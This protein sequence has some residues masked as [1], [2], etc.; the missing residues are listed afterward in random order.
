MSKFDWSKWGEDYWTSLAR[1]LGTAGMAWLGTVAVNGTGMT[2][3]SFKTLPLALLAGAVLPTTFTFIQNNPKPPILQETTTTL[4]VKETI[5]QE[6]KPV[7]KDN[8]T[9]V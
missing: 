7:E 5:T 3:T 2:W 8:E 1:H 9:K 4:T 6:T